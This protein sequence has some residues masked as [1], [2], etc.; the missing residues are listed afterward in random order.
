MIHSSVGDIVSSGVTE[1]KGE[2]T[3][4]PFNGPGAA[5]EGYVNSVRSHTINDS[6]KRMKRFTVVVLDVKSSRRRTYDTNGVE[7]DVQTPKEKLERTGYLFY[8]RTAVEDP[9]IIQLDGLS[10]MLGKG[11]GSALPNG[12]YDIN[13]PSV[14]PSKQGVFEFWGEPGMMRSIE[15]KKGDIVRLKTKGSSLWVESISKRQDI[16]PKYSGEKMG[17]MDKVMNVKEEADEDEDAGDDEWD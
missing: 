16:A 8:K 2:F 10:A 14:H 5:I 15:M 7:I 17:W 9:N 4:G 11:S 1:Y 6:T 3:P 13:Q 12:L